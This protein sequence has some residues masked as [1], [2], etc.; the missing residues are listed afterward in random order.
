MDAHLLDERGY[1]CYLNDGSPYL[2]RTLCGDDCNC[3]RAIELESKESG[4]L[5]PESVSC[6]SI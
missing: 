2:M 4:T 3:L 1:N 6:E 5:E